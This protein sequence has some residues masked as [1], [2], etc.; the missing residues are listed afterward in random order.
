MSLNRNKRS[1]TL[2]FKQE[3]EIDVFREMVKHA[4][5]VVETERP[6]QWRSLD[7]MN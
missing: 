2:N 1:I 6:V 3:G 5:V 7:M 4:D